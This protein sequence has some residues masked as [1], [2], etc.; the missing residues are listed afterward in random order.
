MRLREI[1]GLYNEGMHKVISFMGIKLKFAR[2]GHYENVKVNPKK[3]VFYNYIGSSYGCNPK[4]IAEEIIAQNLGYELV[5][6]V[7]DLKLVNKESFPAVIKIFAVED[8]KAM[9]EVSSAKVIVSNMRLNKLIKAGWRKKAE[10]TYIQTWHGSLGIKKIELAANRLK[11]DR[12]WKKQEE[13][14]R[15]YMDYIIS[16]SIFEDDVF[17]E[18]FSLED[19]KK[20]LRYGHPRNDVFFASNEF[21]TKISEKVHKKLGIDK[22]TKIL[23]YAPSYRDDKSNECYDI[24]AAKVLEAHQK[25][26]GGNWVLMVRLHPRARKFAESLF[27]FS[28]KV[29]D[30]GSYDDMQELLL[31]ADSM[32][33]DYS[34]GIFDFMMNGKPGFIFAIDRNKYDEMRGLYYPLEATPFSVAEDNDSLIKNIKDFD[35]EEYKNRIETF[36]AGKGLTEDGKA[37]ARVVDLIKKIM[38]N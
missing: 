29:V 14:D 2:K 16:N 15:A 25:R 23:L 33:T 32:I 4:Y 18:A 19:G 8:K 26:F 9:S 1:F 36:I 21:K 20:I 10:Q 35:E 34:S 30:A 27:S 31:T 22:E 7:D 24:D 12:F 6:I 28:D 5:W 11:K 13:V 37:S 38:E 3:I 17:K